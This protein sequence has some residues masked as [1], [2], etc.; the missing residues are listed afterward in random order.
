MKTRRELLQGMIV[1]IG[2]ASMLSA[3][4]G[5]AT[6][7]PSNS[8]AV[9]FYNQ[10]ELALVSRI[11]DLIIPRTDTPGALEVNVPGFLDGLMAEWADADTKSSHHQQLAELSSMLGSDF[12]AM[13]EAE[14]EQTLSELDAAAYGAGGSRYGGYR[15][16]K[17]LI[18]Q[19]YFASEDGALQE[20]GWVAVPGRWDPCVEIE[21]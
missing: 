2:G 20:R 1:S 10:Q 8:Q 4:G 3:C 5:V 11:S 19:S 13:S 7:V 16:L 14:A 15:S 18:T 12:T 9:R 6:V 21:S 17:G